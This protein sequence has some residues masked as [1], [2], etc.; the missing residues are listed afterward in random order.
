MLKLP[1][2]IKAEKVMIMIKNLERWPLL[3]LLPSS[4]PLLPPFVE[5]V[6]EDTCIPPTYPEEKVFIN[7]CSCIIALFEPGAYWEFTSKV[8]STDP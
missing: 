4:I 5:I 8:T 6:K 2:I 3:L 7:C 1:R